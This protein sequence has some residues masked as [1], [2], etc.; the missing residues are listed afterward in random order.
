MYARGALLGITRAT[1][2]AHG[3]RATLEAIAYQVRDLVDAMA[4]AGQP[5]RELRADGGGSAN[6]FLMQFQ[7][8][9]LGVPVRVAAQP[10]TTA[11]GAALL[12][13]LGAGIWPTPEALPRLGAARLY[14]PRISAD[15]R[16]TLHAGWLRAVERARGWALPP[17]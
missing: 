13:G 12:A 1:S 11:R 14:T 4:R 10:E 8:D 7:A 3:A 9:L 17:G 16:D 15:Q 2:R 6:E 5:L